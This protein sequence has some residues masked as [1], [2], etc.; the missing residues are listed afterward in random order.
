[1]LEIQWTDGEGGGQG[2]PPRDRPDGEGGRSARHHGAER[3]GQEHAGAGAGRASRL[4]GHRR[5]GALQRR[6]PARAGRRR[7]RPQGRVHGVPVP[8]RDPR[9]EQ[10]LLPEGGAQRQAQGAGPRGTRRHRLHDARE[11]TRPSACRWTRACCSA[12]STRAS[13]AARR[14]ATRSSTWR[15]CSRRWPCSTRPTRASTSTRC[16]SSRTASTRCAAPSAPSSSSPTTS[17]CS[18]TSCPT[19]CT[20]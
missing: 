11:D 9:R 16:G 15:C 6:G 12:R 14:S 19:T 1:M 7:A 2:H 18:T 20:C 4:R 5:R 13:R 10:R 8:G 17:A 3:L